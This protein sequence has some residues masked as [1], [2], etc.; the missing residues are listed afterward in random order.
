M[1]L[2]VQVLLPYDSKR[3]MMIALNDAAAPVMNNSLRLPR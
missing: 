1:R 2:P 3:D